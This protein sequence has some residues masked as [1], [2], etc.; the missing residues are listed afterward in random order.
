LAAPG[1]QV[2]AQARFADE[3]RLVNETGVPFRYFFGGEGQRRYNVT[4]DR[5]VA[6]RETLRVG[7]IELVLYF[8]RPSPR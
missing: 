4:P 8:A 1:T 3:L 7:G 5:L 2:I 6:R